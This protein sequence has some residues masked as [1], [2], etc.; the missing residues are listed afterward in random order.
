M[1]LCHDVEH[2]QRGSAASRLDALSFLRYA[3]EAESTGLNQCHFAGSLAKLRRRRKAKGTTRWRSALSVQAQDSTLVQAAAGGAVAALLFDGASAME[4]HS[5]HLQTFC[6]RN[7]SLRRIL[8]ITFSPDAEATVRSFKDVDS[9]EAFGVVG[10]PKFCEWLARLCRTSSISVILS[11]RAVPKPQREQ[12]LLATE[13]P[14]ASILL[15][16]SL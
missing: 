5:G 6:E 10:R 4:C 1:G 3:R 8:A 11:T 9:A 14:F 12:F 7:A 2:G 13:L 15:L 16:L